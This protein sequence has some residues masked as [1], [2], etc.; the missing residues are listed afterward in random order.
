MSFNADEFIRKAQAEAERVTGREQ[1][2]NS[3][4]NGS[5]APP[6][7]PPPQPIP[8]QW[9][10]M[11]NWDNE[12]VPER[13][14]A[15]RDR[16]PLKQA[17]L[18][19]GEGGT[20][21]SIIELMKDVAHVAGKGLARLDAGAG[22]AFYLGAE[23]DEDEMHIR[24]AAIAK[25]YGVTFKELIDGGLHVLPLLGEDATLCAASQGRPGRDDAPLQADLRGGGR[26]QA[27]EH[28]A[29]TRCRGPSPATRSTGCRSTPSRC[30]CRR[31]P[32]WPSGSVTVLSH[33]SLTGIGSG[34]GI[35]GST[36]WHGAFRFR[37]YLKG[38]KAGRR[39]AA[40]QRSARAGI[41]EEPVRPARERAS[42]CATS[43][44]CSCPR[45]RVRQPRQAG[46]GQR[47]AD[48]VFLDLLPA[49]RPA[50]PQRQRQEDVAELCAG[51]VRQRPAR[52]DAAPGPSRH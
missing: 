13:Q 43:T 52:E 5:A 49:L 41:Q 39:R 22:P 50:G 19:S 8:L 9:L 29:S 47:V 4:A 31:W 18:F 32:W 17:G 40:R 14:W 12:P 42:C 48:D 38:I 20:G 11:S 46:P 26:H 7:P 45:R 35:S 27:E 33:P 15:I 37:Q 6:P 44:A 2:Q 23:D 30:T 51:H 3:R 36:A 25:H 28:L 10:D 34:S 21:K 16:V 24:L 1:K